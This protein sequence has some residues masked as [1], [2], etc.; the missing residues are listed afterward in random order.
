[1]SKKKQNSKVINNIE[2]LNLE[3]DYDKLAEAIVK[4]EIKQQESYSPSREWMKFIL[5]PIFWGIVILSGL[6]SIAIFVLLFQNISDFPKDGS[7]IELTTWWLEICIKFAIAMFS[8]GV[9]IFSV[10]MAKEID[11]EKDR[12]YVAS[13]FSN[14]VAI[15]AL[16]VA[17]VAFLKGVG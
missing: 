3:I 9:C 15:A 12:N 10:F 13:M 1:M 7:L 17:L 4:A 5:T 14:V 6:V 16:I 2:N 11:E 8:S